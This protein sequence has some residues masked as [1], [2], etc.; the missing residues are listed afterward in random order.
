MSGSWL[1]HA[2]C[3]RKSQEQ[4]RRQDTRQLHV[5]LATIIMPHYV[6]FLKAPRLA[7]PHSIA[8]LV[9]ITTDL[10]DSFLAANVELEATVLV[11]GGKSP[12]TKRFFWR[13][14]AREQSIV[15]E[16]IRLDLNKHAVQLGVGLAKPANAT[17]G[18]GVAAD[19]FDGSTVP[20][21]VSAWSP[22]FGASHGPQAEK[23]VLRRLKTHGAPELR[24]WEETGNSIAR[25]IW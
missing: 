14:D 7:S 23:L 3:I 5:R 1:C 25:H 19:V 2:L 20:E 4:D 22:L 6:R 21:I 18:A 12:L 15:F 13:E 8:A 10:G 16:S 24:I 11:Q 9:T 17:K